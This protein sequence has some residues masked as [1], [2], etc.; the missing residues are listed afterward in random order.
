MATERTKKRSAIKFPA[1]C[2]GVCAFSNPN[3]SGELLCWSMPPIVQIIDAEVLNVRGLKVDV[4]S[5]ACIHFKPR[6]HA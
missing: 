3:Q 2:C 4:D 1:N 5:P 6:H